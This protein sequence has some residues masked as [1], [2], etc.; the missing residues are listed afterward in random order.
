MPFTA[1]DLRYHVE[2]SYPLLYAYL[3]RNAQRFLGALKYDAFEVDAVVG[4]VVEQLVR[5]G[6]LGAGDH[7]PPTALDQLTN[8][9]FYAFLGRS[10]RNKAIDRLRKRRVQMST[11]AELTMLDDESEVDPLSEAVESVWGAIPFATPEEMALRLASQKH[12]RDLLKHCILLLRAAPNQLQAVVQE[13]KDIGADDLLQSLLPELQDSLVPAINPH[14][15]Q[16][17]DHAHR[18]LRLCLQQ[19]SANLTVVVA[20]RLTQYKA[21]A[22]G[23]ISV[24]FQTL[25][26]QDLSLSDVRQGLAELAREG[27][28]DWHGEDVVQLAA[29]QVKRLARFYKEE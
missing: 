20:L 23:R 16:H 11:S 28:I 19:Q 1:H 29:D 18:K 22:N 9:Q 17:K 15:S 24:E 14:V 6:L 25:A 26:Q 2:Q 8:A 21:M 10:V 12:M 5:L 7:T 13:L 4:H 27:L 3:Q